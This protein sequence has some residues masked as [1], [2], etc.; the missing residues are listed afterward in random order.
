M[1]SVVKRT[2]C[3]QG[4]ARAHRNALR[5][6]KSLVV[7]PQMGYTASAVMVIMPMG[8]KTDYNLHAVVLETLY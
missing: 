6:Y 1:S 8:P 4:S 2:L 3:A 7:R 5:T